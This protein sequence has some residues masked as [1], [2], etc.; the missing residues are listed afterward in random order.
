[1]EKYGIAGQAT[2]NIMAHAHCM[3][4]T[5]VYRHT[6]KLIN[7]YWFSTAKM[8]ARMHL[9]VMFMRTLLV[10]MIINLL[11]NKISTWQ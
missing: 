2:V 1:V 5:Y 7:G 8:F 6:P 3:L 4:Y 11:V 9:N 10:M